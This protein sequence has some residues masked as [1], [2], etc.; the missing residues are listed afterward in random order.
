MT[1]SIKGDSIN[2]SDSN[3]GKA[4]TLPKV[5]D[6]VDRTFD[7]FMQLPIDIKVIVEIVSRGK[8]FQSFMFVFNRNAPK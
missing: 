8:L 6:S 7:L 3:K 2:R 1:I 5:T 4:A